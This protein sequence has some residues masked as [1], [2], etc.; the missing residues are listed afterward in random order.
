MRVIRT[1]AL[2]WCV[3]VARFICYAQQPSNTAEPPGPAAVLPT[4]LGPVETLPP[5]LVPPNAQ[6]ESLLQE[7]VSAVATQSALQDITLTGAVTVFRGLN[8]TDTGTI[9]L[10]A[11][12]DAQAQVTMN[13]GTGSRTEIRSL[14]SDGIQ[15]EMWA[16]PDGTVKHNPVN[17]LL[18]SHPAWFIPGYVLSALANNS[19]QGSFVA[20]EVR[21]A[22]SVNHLQVTCTSGA[23][24]SQGPYD[25]Y[26]DPATSLPASIV[27]YVQPDF[28]NKSKQAVYRDTR[29]PVEITYS[30]YKPV[31]GVQIPY[32]IQAFVQGKQIY[33]IT[34]SSVALNS[35]ISIPSA[36]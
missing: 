27:F 23:P 34:I 10:S 18:T 24:L 21:N 3:F 20:E 32:R 22:A 6:G 2:V 12:G 11:R 19:P 5:A 7:S 36:N 31:Q 30:N 9:T 35:G 15:A 29:L 13:M 17:S 25:F 1:L 26:L 28:P 4:R 14:S 16:G 8:G 33:D